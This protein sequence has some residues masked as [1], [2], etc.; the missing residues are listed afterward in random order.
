MSGT[1]EKSLQMSMFTVSHDGSSP[2][3]AWA[4]VVGAELR[5]WL[6]ALVAS[7]SVLIGV[8]GAHL[9]LEPPG[10]VIRHDLV[11]AGADVARLHWSA[12]SERV[13]E[14]VSRHFPGYRVSVDGARFPSYVTVSLHDLSDADCRGAHRFADRIEGLVVVAMERPDTTCAFGRSLTWRIMP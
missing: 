1:A 14:A 10:A 7:A 8:Y 3:V 11:R 6:W 12:P 2:E 4:R 13:E 9:A 5:H